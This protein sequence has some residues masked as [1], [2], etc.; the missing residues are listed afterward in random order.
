MQ[1]L[2][3]IYRPSCV[4]FWRKNWFKLNNNH[5]AHLV[6]QGLTILRR[7]VALKRAVCGTRVSLVCGDYFLEP[8]F[9]FAA[10]VFVVFTFFG[11]FA[12]SIWSDFAFFGLSAFTFFGVFTFFGFAAFTTLGWTALIASSL[13]LKLPEAPVPVDCFSKSFFTPARRAVF[14]LALTAFSLSPT[15]KKFLK[16]YFRMAWREE[17]PRSFRASTASRII[18]LYLG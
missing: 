6:G 4:I 7:V 15:L 10:E 11:L 3:L 16:M 8:V 1:S 12:F 17:P 2:S 18:S 9:G 14:S 13:S 5:K